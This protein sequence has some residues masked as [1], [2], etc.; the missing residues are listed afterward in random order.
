MLDEESVRA[1]TRAAMSKMRVRQA[2]QDSGASLE[3]AI[4]DAR[5]AI[6]IMQQLT[7][8]LLRVAGKLAMAEDELDDTPASNS[9]RPPPPSASQAPRRRKR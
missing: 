2:V 7:N 6:R 1:A 5:E 3:Q 4:A 9:G 8:A